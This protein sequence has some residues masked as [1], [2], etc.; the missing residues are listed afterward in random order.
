MCRI[1]TGASWFLAFLV[2]TLFDPAISSVYPTEPVA[3]TTF[4]T[5]Q[6]ATVKWK[7][8]GHY[9]RLKDT[10]LM[11][12]DLHNDLHEK[13]NTY[14]ATLARQVDPVMQSYTLFIPPDLPTNRRYHMRFI[15]FEPSLTIF[16]ADFKLTKGA[17]LPVNLKPGDE[18]SRI[19]GS[20]PTPVP[21]PNPAS[22]PV[23]VTTIHA[24]PLNGGT[25]S[26]DSVT[27]NAG[28]GL[29]KS[30]AKRVDRH[31]SLFKLAFVLW[32]AVVGF[33]LAI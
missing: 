33:S 13:N 2:L 16:T 31:G 1:S 29:K 5:G 6:L 3:A 10:G 22:Q 15:S 8:D 24:N 21:N 25:D 12:I 26:K 20:T 7:D 14:V 11:R 19:A 30:S 32:P 4:P 9:P 23:S 17:F 27:H 18:N 28:G